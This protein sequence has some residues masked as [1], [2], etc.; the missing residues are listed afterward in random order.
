MEKYNYSQYCSKANLALAEIY[1]REQDFNKTI[2]YYLK[3][4][5][6]DFDN[7]HT[8]KLAD[9]Y[10]MLDFFDEATYYFSKLL[11]KESKYASTAQYYFAHISYQQEFYKRA[12][13][14]LNTV[15]VND[16]EELL[17]KDKKEAGKI[18]LLAQRGTPKL[19]KL[20]KLYQQQGI[21]QLIG[22]V[23]S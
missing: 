16:V 22:Q 15:A 13:I 9:S 19:K 8:F 12:L 3:V 21:K 5:N 17:E 20:L 1:Y 7:G 6:H 14:G 4:N 23:E 10:F 11:H 2:A 18:M